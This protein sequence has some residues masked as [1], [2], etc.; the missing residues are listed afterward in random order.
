MKTVGNG[1]YDVGDQIHFCIRTEITLCVRA[2][3][4]VCV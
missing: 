3:V 2:C 4:C 1:V